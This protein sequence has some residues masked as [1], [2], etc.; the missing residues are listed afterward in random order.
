MDQNEYKQL[1]DDFGLSAD[2]KSAGR[3]ETNKGGEQF[4]AGVGGAITGRGA[5]LLIIDDPHSEQD[6]MSPSALENAWEWYSS[7]PRQRLQPGGSIVIV[8]TRWST[9]DLTAKLIK[10]MS[11]DSADQWEVLE[12]PAIMDSGEP[13]WPEYWKNEELE[14]V[15]ASIPVAKWNAQYMQNPTSEEGA[16]VRREW[17]NIWED[18][19]P[20][21]VEYLSLIHI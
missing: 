20:P 5:D 10:R 16:I 18:E 9:I 17:W 14:A 21:P 7:G 3:W 13:L 11:E 6:A 19:E 4:A 1:F 15:K 2:S 8:M 12:L